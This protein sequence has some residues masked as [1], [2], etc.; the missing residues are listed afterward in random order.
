MILFLY[1][2]A[3]LKPIEFGGNVNNRGTKKMTAKVVTEENVTKYVTNVS[4]RNGFLFGNNGKLFYNKTLI[5]KYALQK[6]Q[7]QRDASNLSI[8]EQIAKYENVLIKWGHD[9][10]SGYTVTDAELNE[11]DGRVV[12]DNTVNVYRWIFGYGIREKLPSETWEKIK[13]YAEYHDGGESDQDLAEDM[14]YGIYNLSKYDLKGWAYSKEAINILIKEG[15]R[16][17]FHDIEIS[18]TSQISD[19][20]DTENAEE[21]NRYDAEKERE[22]NSKNLYRRLLD[23][24]DEYM[25]EEDCKTLS[26]LKKKEILIPQI[27][28]EGH[29]IYGGGK[30]LLID[31]TY[32]YI[33]KNNGHDGDDWSQNN[34]GTGGA[35]A[36]ATRIK[37]DDTV[38]N[39]MLDVVEFCDDI[40]LFNTAVKEKIRIRTL[41][42][43]FIEAADE[44]FKPELFPIG[45]AKINRHFSQSESYIQ[46]G[47]NI[48][49][50][51]NDEYALNAKGD[52][53]EVLSFEKT[54]HR[55]AFV[56]SFFPDW[57]GNDV[58]GRFIINGW[59]YFNINQIIPCNHCEIGWNKKNLF[60]EYVEG[61]F[62][63]KFHKHPSVVFWS[64][65]E[66]TKNRFY[67]KNTPDCEALGEDTAFYLS[68]PHSGINEKEILEQHFIPRTK[69]Y[70]DEPEKGFVYEIYRVGT[71]SGCEYFLLDLTFYGH[72]DASTDSYLFR[73]EMET[74]QYIKTYL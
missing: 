55:D 50:I 9:E 56:K 59:V 68:I 67:D 17:K 54:E 27:G 43:K 13:P 37:I 26:S 7:V 10:E 28:V 15:F 57:F 21:K 1:L 70:A 3:N 40:N 63:V 20:I 73:T 39:W 49:S 12:E 25:N 47:D 16:V 29:N 35:G 45:E 4:N 46:F 69:I 61:V 74:R 52:D 36:I 23:F 71:F 44:F 38:T 48:L 2:C 11:K 62:P 64:D 41:Y 33:I 65:G 53:Y 42:N 14:G 22:E 19:I 51:C 32:L 30:Y 31:D 8:D 34:F 6:A 5:E 60:D 66:I 24:D 18:S 72:D 58:A